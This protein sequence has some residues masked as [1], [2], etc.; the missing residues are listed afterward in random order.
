[1][2]R[3]AP[4]SGGW[5]IRRRGFALSA[6]AAL[7]LI[8]A[9]ALAADTS[10]DAK[11]ALAAYRCYTCHSDQEPLAGPAFI[12]IATRYRGRKDAVSYVARQI[13]TGAR[14]GG[15]W[16]MPPHP[17]VSG[18]EARAMARYIISLRD[19]GIHPIVR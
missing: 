9:L 5:N 7:W 1:M 12:D 8:S 17:E 14:T 19:Q 13:A 10:I 4:A 2:A 6:A 18:D 15:P 16:H 11:A 3:Y